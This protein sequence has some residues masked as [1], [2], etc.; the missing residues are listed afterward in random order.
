MY[1]RKKATAAATVLVFSH[2]I[3]RKAGQSEKGSRPNL[4]YDPTDE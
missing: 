4:A 3:Q 1:P 2:N